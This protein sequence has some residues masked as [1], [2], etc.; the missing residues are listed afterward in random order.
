MKKH[1]LCLLASAICFLV[2]CKKEKDIAPQ[3]ASLDDSYL[4]SVTVSGAREVQLDTGKQ[5]IQVIL[6]ETFTSN[7]LDLKFD[8]PE[9]SELEVSDSL[10][11]Q[12]DQIRFP[13]VGSGPLTFKVSKKQQQYPNEKRYTVFV[14]HEGRLTARLL[15][16]PV[17]YPAEDEI[18]VTSEFKFLS[19][20]GTI[21]ETPISPSNPSVT[22]SDPAKG[23]SKDGEASAELNYISIQECAQFLRSENLKL[24]ISYADKKFD[25]PEIKQIR[26]ASV[27]GLLDWNR[28]L[29]KTFPK[30][31]T[32]QIQGGLFL[33]E[34][35]YRIELSN[36]RMPQS[37]KLE[38]TFVNY[39]LLTFALPADLP[40]DQYL[41]QIYED[42]TLIGKSAEPVASDSIKAS[43]GSVWT[44]STDCPTFQILLGGFTSKIVLSKGQTF[45]AM[46][47]PAIMD[48]QYGKP[49][50][51]N[52]PLPTLELKSGNETL[53]LLP[54][55][56]ADWCYGDG[57]I[58]TYYGAF[59]VPANAPSGKYDARFISK[60]NAASM[61]YWNQIEIR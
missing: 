23:L 59:K 22:L 5:I 6:P 29:F 31:K 8:L 49:M 37:R 55:A 3:V 50:D 7:V 52:K 9:T 1:C 20:I 46:P 61:P 4:K 27:T 53:R 33:P 42:N 57:G 39:S 25:F 60:D 35:R 26:R 44:E 13:Y 17:F 2:A 28:K 10:L 19:G 16:A 54:A 14:K 51:P 40:D 43:V 32:L 18:S 12:A 21:P 30:G 38:A 56:K 15:I 48:A 24:S 58:Y 34:N 41:A 36:D 11:V 47:F 45:Y